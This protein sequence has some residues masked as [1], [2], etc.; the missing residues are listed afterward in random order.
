MKT[1]TVEIPWED[2]ESCIGCPFYTTFDPSSWIDDSY[3]GPDEEKCS[4][5]E[6]KN[7]NYVWGSGKNFK[8]DKQKFCKARRVT[9]EEEE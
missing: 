8:T 2:K 1:R 9:I 3:Y 6:L 4:L 7:P 5:Y